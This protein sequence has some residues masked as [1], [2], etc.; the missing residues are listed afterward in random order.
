MKKTDKNITSGFINKNKICSVFD[1]NLSAKTKTYCFKHYS[2]YFKTGNPLKT[3]TGREWGKRNVCIIRDCKGLVEGKN[4]CHK[5]YLRFKK[6]GSPLKGARK[7][8]HRYTKEGY[9]LLY[10][11]DWKT[12]RKDN[13]VLEHRYVIEKKLGRS[14][15]KSEIVHHKN[16]IRDDNRLSNLEMMTIK[17]H[18]K[19]SSPIICPHCGKEV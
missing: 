7:I 14:L 10:K 18:Y 17:K 15:K 4:Y 11:P 1:C 6:Y 19:G 16:G 13:Y 9:V 3:P 8:N 12:A 5:H 2:R